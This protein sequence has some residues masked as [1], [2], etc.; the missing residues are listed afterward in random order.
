MN[1]RIISVIKKDYFAY[2]YEKAKEMIEEAFRLLDLDTNHC[3][4]AEWNPLSEI[5]SPGMN[6]LI[7]PNLV[8]DHNHNLDNGTKCLYT[9]VE[10]VEPVLQYVIKALNG[11]GKIVIGDAPMQECDFDMLIKQSG[12]KDLVDRYSNS[13]ID[14]EL[15]D[16]RDLKS[17]VRGGSTNIPVKG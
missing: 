11:K 14:I 16:F 13:G 6:V 5:I 15:V 2:S 1:D 7:K 8:M 9:Q 12:Y 17:V 10:V 4:T 3:N